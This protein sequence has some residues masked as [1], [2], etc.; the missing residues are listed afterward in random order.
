MKFC[1]SNFDK[2]MNIFK[3]TNS[4]LFIFHLIPIFPEISLTKQYFK[5]NVI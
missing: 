3:N 4:F 2:K 5:S 1:K